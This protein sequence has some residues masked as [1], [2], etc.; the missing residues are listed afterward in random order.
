MAIVSKVCDEKYSLG[1]LLDG[2]RSVNGY[3]SDYVDRVILLCSPETG[4]V[5]P[6]YVYRHVPMKK[7]GN[8]PDY[9][10]S[11]RNADYYQDAVDV[12]E[13]NLFYFHREPE[14]IFNHA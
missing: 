7:G 14:P 12:T 9:L 11:N 3:P 10:T 5:K 2:S 8:F 4:D 13:H 6:G 1:N